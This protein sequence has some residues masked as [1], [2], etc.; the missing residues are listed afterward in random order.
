MNETYIFEIIKSKKDEG[1]GTWEL[2]GLAFDQISASDILSVDES[3]KITEG[4]I[5][6]TLVKTYD[7]VVEELVRGLT[8]TLIVNCDE[9]IDLSKHKYLYRTP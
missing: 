9:S 2:S 7:R 8:G 5:E 3:S 4:K 6:V 1:D